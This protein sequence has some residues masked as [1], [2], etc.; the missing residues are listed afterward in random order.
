MLA[1]LL[2]SM[3]GYASPP[4]VLAIKRPAQAPPAP[5]RPERIMRP[6][7]AAG[8][9]NNLLNNQ[10]MQLPFNRPPCNGP[11]PAVNRGDMQPRGPLGDRS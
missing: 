3:N 6:T 7:N 11:P 2:S 4:R 1:Y 9:G 8:N 5:E 10:F